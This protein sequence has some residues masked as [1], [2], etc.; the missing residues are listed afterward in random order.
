[1]MAF[2][3]FI[4]LSP[5]QTEGLLRVIYQIEVETGDQRF[6]A[7]L[8]LNKWMDDRFSITCRKV[9]GGTFFTYWAMPGE[10]YLLFPKDK[11]AFQGKD[12]GPFGLFPGGPVLTRDQWL[13]LL[14]G[15]IPQK[16]SHFNVVEEGPWRTLAHR[17]KAFTIRW[18]EKKRSHKKVFRPE[19]LQPRYRSGIETHPLPDFVNFWGADETRA[20]SGN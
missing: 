14:S 10:D 19:V 18:R 16:L 7:D 2:L 9:P 11:L 1:M 5:Q 8:A 15:P 20:P 3:L 12:S 13:A 17:D 6:T 4:C